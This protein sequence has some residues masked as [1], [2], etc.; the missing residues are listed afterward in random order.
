MFLCFNLYIGIA[1]QCYLCVRAI[2]IIL[3]I[4]FTKKKRANKNPIFNGN[5]W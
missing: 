1:I 5:I 4:K 3:F 2:K